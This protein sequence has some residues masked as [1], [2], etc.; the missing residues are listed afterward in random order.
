M[1]QH[2]L[3]T[4]AKAYIVCALW[5]STDVDGDPLDDLFTIDDI[6]PDSLKKMKD[7][8]ADFVSG[9]E[10]ALHENTAERAGRDFWLTRNGHGAGFWDGD[11]PINGDALTEASKTYGESDLYVGD[12]G[13]LYI[14]P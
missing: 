9:N 2:Y 4:F 11:W 14:T 10:K 5:S 8:C 12:D 7:D 13:K 1:D 6:H 3:E